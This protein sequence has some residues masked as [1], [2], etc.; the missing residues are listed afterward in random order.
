MLTADYI[1]DCYYAKTQEANLQHV[2]E[3]FLIETKV[4]NIIPN[5]FFLKWGH[6]CY[7]PFVVMDRFNMS[8]SGLTNARRI[9]FMTRT[10]IPS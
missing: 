6:L 1:L 8:H 4:V 5:T 9:S 2:F 10:L 7:L 3:G